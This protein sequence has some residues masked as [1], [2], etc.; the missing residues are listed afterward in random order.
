MQ[1]KQALVGS[2]SKVVLVCVYVCMYVC[3]S[4]TGLRLKCTDLH[5]VYVPYWHVPL[6][7]NAIAMDVKDQEDR[8]RQQ[9]K[10]CIQ[11]YRSW[12]TAQ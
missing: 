5:I 2:Q 4:A 12:L 8:R 3:M 9:D 6:I 7:M 10:E 11:K 1:V